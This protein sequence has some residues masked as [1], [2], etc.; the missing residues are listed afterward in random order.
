M[1]TMTDIEL[2]RFFLVLKLHNEDFYTDFLMSVVT[3]ETPSEKQLAGLKK[4]V[5]GLKLKD[6]IARYD[7]DEFVPYF[8]DEVDFENVTTNEILYC[9]ETGQSVETDETLMFNTHI[10]RFYSVDAYK[11]SFRIQKPTKKKLVLSAL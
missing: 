1:D 6:K 9:A 2:A 3:A 10:N 5:D 8:N 7:T 11:K 4:C